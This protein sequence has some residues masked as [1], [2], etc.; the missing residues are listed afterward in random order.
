MRTMERYLGGIE[1]TAFA[2]VASQG[3]G[4]APA[5]GLPHHHVERRRRHTPPATAV[6][7]VFI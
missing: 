7:I 2:G 1:Y 6:A 4:G 3:R 5:D